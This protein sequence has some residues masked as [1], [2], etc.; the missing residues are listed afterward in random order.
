MTLTASELALQHKTATPPI[1]SIIQ[2]TP[3]VIYWI[4]TRVE[5][6]PS[7]PDATPI[8]KPADESKPPVNVDLLDSADLEV[9]ALAFWCDHFGIEP[10]GDFHRVNGQ[11]VGLTTP[12]LSRFRTAGD[13]PKPWHLCK[14]CGTEWLPY[15]PPKPG[16]LEPPVQVE[17]CDTC[18]N[19]GTPGMPGYL[20]P[21]EDMVVYLLSALR[22]N[23][24]PPGIYDDRDYG[25]HKIRQRNY[26]R[27]PGLGAA[28][29]EERQEEAAIQIAR[30][31][32][33][34]EIEPQLW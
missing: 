30:S 17:Q 23:P 6:K 1:T 22:H 26:R 3:A 8:A 2:D 27:W 32:Y 5:D 15:I 12:T 7:N 34:T 18:L 21:V 10:A 11:I 25:L 20:R 31:Y 16:D 13:F 9:R 33:S 28:F 4:R 24:P 19:R 14:T 29:T